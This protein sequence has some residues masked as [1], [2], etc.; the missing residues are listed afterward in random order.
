MNTKQIEPKA[1]FTN[2]GEKNASIISL[3]NFFDYHFDDG[4]GKVSYQLIGMES[5][6]GMPESAIIYF[7]GI[8]EIPSSIIVQWGS[9]DSIIWDYCANKLG[10][11]LL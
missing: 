4:A 6:D 8:I 3:T 11:T 7:S 5:F 9:D 2:D 1:I 10:I